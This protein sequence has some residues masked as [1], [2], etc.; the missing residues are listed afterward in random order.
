MECIKNDTI[1]RYIP[2]FY[3]RGGNSWAGKHAI[4][5]LPLKVVSNLFFMG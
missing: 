3:L 4:S 2:Q 1:S 5:D